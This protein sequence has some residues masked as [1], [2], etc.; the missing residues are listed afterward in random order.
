MRPS[1]SLLLAL[2][3]SLACEGQTPTTWSTVPDEAPAATRAFPLQLRMELGQLRDAAL[4]DDYAYRQLEYLTDSI[5]PRP[6]GSRQ[7]DAAAHYVADEM[8]RLGLQVRLEP[9]PV[10]RF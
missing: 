1:W 8:R 5:G 9:V 6:Q 10:H 2:L 4:G 3:I 7:A